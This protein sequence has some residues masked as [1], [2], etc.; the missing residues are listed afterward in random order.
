MTALPATALVVGLRSV[1]WRGHG[2]RW[3]VAACPCAGAD[4][5]L[6]NDD[7]LSAAGRASSWSSRAR[8]FRARHR[9]VTAARATSMPVWSE[10]ELGYRLLR[11]RP[12]VG[13]TGTKGKTTTSELLGAILRAARPAR[14][15]RRQ[16]RPAA[17]G[18]RAGG[19]RV[20]RVRALVASSS[21]TSTSSTLEVAVL[22]NL[23]PDHLDRHGT[24]ERYRAA[25]LRIF[26]RAR[27]R[28]VP[29][30][31]GLR[32]RRVRGRRRAARGAAASRDCTTA[33]TPPPRRP[34]H[35]SPE[36]TTTSIARALALLPGRPAPA[37]A[38][39]RATTASAG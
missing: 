19:G 16:R 25:K 35:G 38:R 32:R 21:R 24:F 39:A 7:D 2:C 18:A 6:G 5:K 17:D 3:S 8:A 13:V 9:L 15:R 31:S 12:F 11:P 26:E 34:R 14:R 20:G 23:E 4:R 30:G 1:R 10:V 27:H 36:S 33:R 22:L 37:R 28:V 29:R